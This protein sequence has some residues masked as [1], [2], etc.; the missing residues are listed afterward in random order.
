V[1]LRSGA[2]TTR[3]L[4]SCSSA[5]S[6]EPHLC[7]TA[8]PER[9]SVTNAIHGPLYLIDSPIDLYYIIRNLSRIADLGGLSEVQN[10]AAYS[11]LRRQQ[12][13]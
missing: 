5:M 2:A 12:A 4:L 10:D 7:H 13:N 11:H 8:P 9:A 1:K 6:V 3:P